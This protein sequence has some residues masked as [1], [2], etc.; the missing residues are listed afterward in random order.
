MGYRYY[1]HF[2]P[3][4]PSILTGHLARS[5][6]TSSANLIHTSRKTQ[7]VKNIIRI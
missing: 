1:G 2:P 6:E 3:P 4:P 7:E 5:S